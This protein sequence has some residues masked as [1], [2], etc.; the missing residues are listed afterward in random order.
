MTQLRE[1]IELV[2]PQGA[3]TVTR[4]D[5]QRARL[6][7]LGIG[8]LQEPS[9]PTAADRLGDPKPTPDQIVQ[10]VTRQ[11]LGHGPCQPGWHTMSTS[12]TVVD[13]HRDLPGRTR[14]YAIVAS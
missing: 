11:G 2:K 4:N 12:L 7:G 5:P 1:L 6:P 3:L 10:T 13:R 14:G 8:D 9:G